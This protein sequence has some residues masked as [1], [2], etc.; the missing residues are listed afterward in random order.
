MVL[1]TAVHHYISKAALQMDLIVC[2]DVGSFPRLSDRRLKLLLLSDTSRLELTKSIVNILYNIVHSRAAVTTAAQK[3]VLEQY[4]TLV[5]QLLDPL[6]S[7]QQKKRIL[8]N[9]TRLVKAIAQ[10]CPQPS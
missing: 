4:E 6:H 8:V 3:R 10:S 1:D 5:W 2:S 7:L 9:N